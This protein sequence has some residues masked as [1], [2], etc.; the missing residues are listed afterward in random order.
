MTQS[1]DSD[2]RV[3]SEEQYRNLWYVGDT[4]RPICSIFMSLDLHTGRWRVQNFYSVLLWRRKGPTVPQCRTVWPRLQ[5]DEESAP[6]VLH[7][8]TGCNCTTLPLWTP[9]VCL[10]LGG[11][12]CSFILLSFLNADRT[13]FS[14]IVAVAYLT[15]IPTPFFFLTFIELFN[16]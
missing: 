14:L 12:S 3:L 16:I 8:L 10:A 4:M 13:L 2:R 11:Q 6:R 9:T 1:S 15:R 7:A 5:N